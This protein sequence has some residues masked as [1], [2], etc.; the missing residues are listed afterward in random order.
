VRDITLQGKVYSASTFRFF[1][2]YNVV[3]FLYLVMTIVLSLL[4]RYLERRMS[5]D[6]RAA[7]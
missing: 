7:S 2:T 6:G 4:V 5:S 1:Q 3:A